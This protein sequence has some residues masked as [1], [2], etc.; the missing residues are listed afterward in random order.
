MIVDLDVNNEDVFKC[1]IYDVICLVFYYDGK[2]VDLGFVG[3]CMVYKGD[4]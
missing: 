3:F 1:Y 4:M 2:L